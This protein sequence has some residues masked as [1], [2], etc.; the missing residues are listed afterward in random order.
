MHP[1]NPF[2][3]SLLKNFKKF[4]MS[5]KKKSHFDYSV[6]YKMQS[7]FANYD[8]PESTNLKVDSEDNTI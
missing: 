1:S 6:D 8:Q 4:C 3:S 5:S 2:E 7:G